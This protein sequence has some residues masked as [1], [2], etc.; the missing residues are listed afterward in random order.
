MAI[1]FEVNLRGVPNISFVVV[2]SNDSVV[3]QRFQGNAA[4]PTHIHG[5][6]C[7]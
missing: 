2:F 4:L 6:Y 1:T 7:N 5:A 3:A